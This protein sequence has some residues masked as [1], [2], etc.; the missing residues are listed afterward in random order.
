MG[1]W[2]D[3]PV[4]YPCAYLSYDFFPENMIKLY[5]KFAFVEKSDKPGYIRLAIAP[6]V[7]VVLL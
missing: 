2:F 5:N 6:D 3:V 4:E 7:R 1:K